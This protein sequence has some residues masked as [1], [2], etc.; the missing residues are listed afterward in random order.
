MRR[1][2]K[3]DRAHPSCADRGCLTTDGR[4]QELASRCDLDRRNA[5]LER[6]LTMSQRAH[7]LERS[8]R[9]RLSDELAAWKRAATCDFCGCANAHATDCEAWAQRTGAAEARRDLNRATRDL[10][11]VRILYEEERTGR[12]R[13]ERTLLERRHRSVRAILEGDDGGER[14]KLAGDLIHASRQD[15]SLTRWPIPLTGALLTTEQLAEACWGI[16]G[17]GPP[18]PPARAT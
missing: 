14:L 8:L 5:E 4:L 9:V 1:R 12:L 18:F 10:D 7:E 6:E 15:F 11:R 2:R 16:G 3:V 13:A 17:F